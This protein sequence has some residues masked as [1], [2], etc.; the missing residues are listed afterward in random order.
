MTIYNG[1]NE[2]I[3]RQ[4][5]AY[6]KEAK[7]YS[8][9]SIDGVAAAIHRFEEYTRFRDFRAFHIEQAVAF[10]RKLAEQV[11]AR[12]GQRLS[13]ATLHSTL[14]ALRSFFLWL[15]GRP[16]FRSR[17]SYADAEYFNLSEK[18][19]RIAKAHRSHQG[20]TLDQVRHVIA[21]MPHGTAIEMRDR[22]LIA[23]TLLVGARDNAI[24][25]FKLKHID[26]E[27]ERVD[28]DAREVRTKFS[29][30][31]P[32]WFFPVGEEVR[33][34]V[35][36]W[37][38]YLREDKLWGPDDPL[39]PAT[40]VSQNAEGHFQ[41]EG[42][43]RRHWSDAGSIRSIFKRAFEA[44]GLPYFN[45][46]SLRKTLAQVGE[47]QCA[48][49]EEFKAWSQNLGH[50]KVMTTFSSYGAVAANRQEEILK[51]MATRDDASAVQDEMAELARLAQRLC[52]RRSSFAGLT[53][54]DEQ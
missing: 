30:T 22:A 15:A 54:L 18:E 17:L 26:L 32:T 6:L 10:K 41:A 28:Q 16:G 27:A 29:K 23:F 33:E 47:R 40:K 5:F 42:V 13:K 20:P 9:T 43:D 35:V 3:K 7:R 50:E 38:H 49:P 44:A 25:S 1:P 8:E 2:R 24:A 39:F 4:Y 52:H 48:T 11:S 34:I 46:H 51:S 36:E 37:V 12:T 21:C 45:P 19:T 14:M 31:F 53:L